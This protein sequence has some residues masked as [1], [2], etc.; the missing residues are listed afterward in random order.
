MTT[1][2]PYTL[3]NFLLDAKVTAPPAFAKHLEM[4]WRPR[5]DQVVG[6]NRKLCNNRFGLFDDPGVGKT[7]QLQAFALQMVAQGNRVLMLMPP[8][9]LGQYV[10][11][12]RETFSEPERFV[13]WHVLTQGPAKR[14][15][16]Y[17]LWDCSGEWPQ[18]L[19]M[20]YE[21]FVNETRV[22]KGEKRRQKMAS[23]FRELYRV[24]DIDEGHKLC[25]HD[26]LIHDCLSWH[27]GEPEESMLGI[28]TG[29]PMMTNPLNAYGLIQLLNPTAYSNFGQFERKHAEYTKIRLENP[30]PLRNGQMLEWV[31]KL[32]GFRNAELIRQNLYANGRR[33]IKEQVLDLKKPQILE[34]PV[35]LGDEHYRLYR[36]LEKERILEYQGQIIAGGINEQRLR[37]AL[38]RIITNPEAFMAEGVPIY[39]A[40]LDMLLQKIETHNNAM[41]EPETNFPNKIIVFC[42]LRNTAAW[43][44]KALAAYN[45]VVLNG[46]T[47]DKE[48]VRRA[49]LEKDSCRILIANPE[50]AGFG[51]NFQGVSRVC[52]FVEPTSIPGEFKQAMERIYR[53]G[54]KHVC[55]VYVF[56]AAGTI[57]P[58][59]TKEMLER[60]KEINRVNQ[61]SVIFSTFFRRAA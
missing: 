51:L 43:L 46:D 50:S 59:A 37:Q 26:T 48:G 22:K 31:M 34:V 5:Q 13:S 28:A 6:L 18:M 2:N 10:A 55:Q 17:E 32:T 35:V 61:D 45:P 15:E 39:N 40:V 30:R 60:T 41:P 16:L 4:P 54:Q 53:G 52:I 21:M 1:S 12:L 20:S 47:T 57:A 23:V 24:V 19:L 25:G 29:T 36:Q 3:E 33:V 7:V 49:F 42:N 27:L 38:L 56:R 11:S 44:K 9:L 58:R 14:Q 8:V